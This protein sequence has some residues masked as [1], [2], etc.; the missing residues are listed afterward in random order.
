VTDHDREFGAT[1]HKA[2]LASSVGHLR[3][4]ELSPRNHGTLF[5]T[6]DCLPPSF[7][8][9]GLVAGLPVPC[10]AL[11]GE[12]PAFGFIL[13]AFGFLPLMFLD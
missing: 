11:Y 7:F 10:A 12:T 5:S 2:E 1:P 9:K 8:A 3:R 13:F 4:I 6:V